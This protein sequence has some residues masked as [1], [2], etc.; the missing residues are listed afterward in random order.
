MEKVYHINDTV[1]DTYK[2]YKQLFKL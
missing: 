1:E 2:L